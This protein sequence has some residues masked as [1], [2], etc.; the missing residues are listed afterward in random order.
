[1]AYLGYNPIKRGRPS[2][3]PLLC[4]NGITKDFWHG[5]LRPGDTYTATGIIELLDASFSKLPPSVNT[6]II[7][8][9]K[10][11]Y[12]HKTIEYLES[13]SAFFVILAKL[14]KPLK[15]K[16]S[17]LI[18]QKHSPRHRNSRVQICT[19]GLEKRI[20]LCINKTSYIGRPFGTTNAFYYGKIQ[21]SG[22]GN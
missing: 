18:Y 1:M 17:T 16:I 6:V 2:Y 7:R 20:P 15:G 12:D 4:F 3:H 10:G 11:F 21:L 8:A 14:T 5:E 9:D 22:Y 19:P 13:K